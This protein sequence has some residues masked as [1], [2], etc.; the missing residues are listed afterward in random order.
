MIRSNPPNGPLQSSR[1]NGGPHSLHD[2]LPHPPM[3][4]RFDSERNLS[5]SVATIQPDRVRL[6]TSIRMKDVLTIDRSVRPLTKSLLRI[7]FLPSQR[8]RSTPHSISMIQARSYSATTY[9]EVLSERLH[10]DHDREGRYRVGVVSSSHV[11]MQ[12]RLNADPQSEIYPSPASQ[13][14]SRSGH[15]LTLSLGSAPSRDQSPP[16]LNPICH[17]IVGSPST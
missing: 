10:L 16:P 14:M 6:V 15:P 9:G 13:S 2:V 7:F 17:L 11:S 3:S 4:T 12:H 8:L 5:L 1:A